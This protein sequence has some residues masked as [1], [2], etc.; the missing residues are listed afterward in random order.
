MIL[1]IGNDKKVEKSIKES[2]FSEL[3]IWERTHME[4]WIAEYPQ[5]LGE[6]LLTAT[7]EYDKFDKTNNRLDILAIDKTGKLVVI[8]LKRDIADKFIDLQ[9]IHYAAYCSTLNYEHIVDMMSDYKGKSKEEIKSEINEFIVN[10][11]FSDF[12][13]QPRIILVANDFKEDTLSAVL[14]LI[15]NGLDITCVKLEPYQ[16]EHKIIIKP[17]IIIPLP[18]AKDFMMQIVEKKKIITKTKY[19]D[20]NSFIEKLLENSSKEEVHIVN[21]ILKWVDPKIDYIYWGQGTKTGA[22]V[23]IVKKN[24]LDHQLFVVK[25]NAVIEISFQYYKNKKAFK[26][27]DKRKQLLKK[28]NSI[29]TINISK[30][31]ISS[32]PTI[33]IAALKDEK[34]LIKFLEIFEWFIEEINTN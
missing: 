8:E 13:N 7:T 22:F 16:I 25:T 33:Y 15:D 3:G 32:R 10:D 2:K 20:E 18:E 5:I 6:E 21:E 17:E 11:E 34:N 31:A 27:E 23:P 19:W 12:D 29:D 26:A 14:W 28:L 30:D 1:L 24:G 4:E 9:A